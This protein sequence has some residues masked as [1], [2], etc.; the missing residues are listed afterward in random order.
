M[1]GI[2]LDMD[3]VLY[4]SNTL[5]EGAA[6]TV[7]WIQRRGIPHL[8]ITNTTSR[9]RRALAEKLQRF[10]IVAGPEQILTPCVAAADWLRQAGDGKAALFVDAR[11]RA[12]FSGIPVLPDD[13]ESGARYVV[14]GD[15][16]KGWDYL[17]LNR[18]FRL[19]HSD[20]AAVLVALGMTRYWHAEDGLRLDTA[21]FVAA[22]SHATGCGAMIFGKPASSFFNAAV[23]MLGVAAHEV[24][25]VGDDIHTDIQGS[26]AAG[27]AAVLV[28]TG[29]FRERDLEQDIVPSAV[30]DSIADLPRWW[31]SQLKRFDV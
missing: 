16:G 28:R 6:E 31:D 2:L 10:G 12:E 9:D 13:A 8:F 15:L 20:P 19:L 25:M 4:N 23:G 21:P 26:M 5:V 1:R 17:T 11:A 14:V 24:V 30:L 29:K 7:G 27:L 18:A 3:G 22:L